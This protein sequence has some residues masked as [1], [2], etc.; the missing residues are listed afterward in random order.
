MLFVLQTFR[1][2]TVYSDA[3]R[4]GKISTRKRRYVFCVLLNKQLLTATTD[5]PAH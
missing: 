3:E 5:G 4:K 2:C 1:C